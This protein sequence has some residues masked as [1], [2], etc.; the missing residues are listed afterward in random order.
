MPQAHLYPVQAQAVEDLNRAIDQP[1]HIAQKHLWL[2]GEM[3]VGKTYIASG[4]AQTRQAKRVLI[5]SPATITTKWK[6]VYQSFNPQSDPYI[7]RPRKDKDSD[8][9]TDPHIVIVKHHDLYQFVLN[10]YRLRAGDPT[11]RN[12]SDIILPD[13]KSRTDDFKDD[14]RLRPWDVMHL[15]RFDF[16][17]IIFDEVHTVRPTTQEYCA[18]HYLSSNETCP[19][20][21][22]TGTIFSQN[23]E[24]LRLMLGD[25]NP[26][27][28]QTVLNQ[29]EDDYYNAHD[30]LDNPAW[31]FTNIWQY[32]A[33][34][35]SL[36]DVDNLHKQ[37]DIDQEI[38]PLHG[39]TLSPEQRAWIQITNLQLGQLHKSTSFKNSL[40]TNYLDLPSQSQPVIKTR[41]IVQDY[42]YLHN[43]RV[44]KVTKTYAS[45][46]LTPTK[47]TDTPKFKQVQSILKAYPAKTLIFVQDRQL[48]RQLVKNLPH[49]KSL[50]SSLAKAKY[51]TYI[52]QALADGTDVFIVTA[53][54][55]SVGV[56]IDTAD[57]IIWYQ[58]PTDVATIIQAQRRIYRL[59]STKSSR[60]FYLFYQGTNQEEII[61]QVSASSVHNAA[62]YNVRQDDN[63]AKISEILFPNL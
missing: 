39:L 42:P 5:V 47:L 4:L 25:M 9:T 45:M 28:M 11:A 7:Y 27:L 53:K 43:H 38:M 36:A 16:D 58:V 3:G 50:P 31:F 44:H 52:N 30:H 1:N 17:L 34:Q 2:S 21:Y 26:R 54:Q 10:Q 32:I 18:M 61:Q 33:V 63:L 55:I 13:S 49:A 59:N 19:I 40:I 12:F 35:I 41:R 56:D 62:S 23:H 57:Q 8:L 29:Y 37:D 48:L 6:Q 51:S 22:L 60:I 46:Q 14:H 24:Y 15:P 20:L